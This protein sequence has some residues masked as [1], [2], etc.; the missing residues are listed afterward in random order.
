MP[1][2]NEY[3]GVFE[4]GRRVVYLNNETLLY[5]FDYPNWSFIGTGSARVAEA[6][7]CNEFGRPPDNARINAFLEEVV[8][9]WPGREGWTLTSADIQ[10]WLHE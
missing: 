10:E 1:K 7:I 8:A 6:V 3:R 2:A 9:K 5:A 4:N